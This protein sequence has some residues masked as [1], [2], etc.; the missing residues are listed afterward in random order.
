YG[1][2][3]LTDIEIRAEDVLELDVFG[4]EN[5]LDDVKS[6]INEAEMAKRRF[7]EIAA[8]A[9]LI[10]QGY[11]GRPITNKHLQASSGVLYDVFK[12]YDPDNLLIRQAED[13]VLSLQLEQS[14][15][16]EA[17]RRINQQELIIKNPPKPTPFAFPIMVDRLREKLTSEKLEDRILKLQ[18][19]LEKYAE[20]GE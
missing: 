8:I 4:E 12:E 15:L 9:G 18:L 2:E 6:S 13:E 5:L 10:F 1:F 14:R 17:I 7:R 20:T 19:Q 16:T 11:P 3:L